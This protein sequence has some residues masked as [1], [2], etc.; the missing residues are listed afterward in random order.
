MSLRSAED[1]SPR[2]MTGGMAIARMLKAHGVGPVF[3]MGGFQLLPF[4]EGARQMGIDHYLIDDE[5]SGAFAADAF[6]RVS[7]RVGVVDATLGPGATNLVTGLAE[8]H[9]AGVPI[10]AIIGDAHRL[11]AG[12]N[13][14][15]ETRQLDVLAPVCKAVL[16]IEDTARIPEL[17][18]RAFGL[19]TSG[20]PGPV[21]VSVPEDI[22]HANVTFAD[23]DFWSDPV[24]V[25]GTARRVRPDGIDVQRAAEV[26]GSAA[27]PLIL[28]GGGVHLSGGY[29]ELAAL[30]AAQSIPVAHTLS[31][32]GAI[33]CTHPLSVG[34]FGR[35][36]RIANDLINESD[37]LLVVG[38][39][40][41]EIAT[42]RYVLPPDGVPLIQLDIDPGEI[43]R[44]ARTTVGLW[45]DAGLGMHDLH[46]AVGSATVDRSAYVEDVAER[47]EQ[48]YASTAERYASDERPIS[49]GRVMGEFNDLLSEDAI[50][51]ADGGFASHWAG[52]LYDTKRAGR[53]FV[54]DRGFA[55][56]GYGLP[57]SLGA[58]LAAGNAPVVGV[59]GDGGFNMSAGGLE[60]AQRIGAPFTLVVVNNA[61]SGYVKALQHAVYGPESYSASDLSELNFARIA[62][63][64]GCR[65]IRVEDPNDLGPALTEAIGCT[66]AP[67]VLDVVV[68]RDAG[69]MLPSADSRTL[70]VAPGDRPA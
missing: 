8:S 31:G 49:M 24:A 58:K 57:G 64:Y 65:G 70:T 28:A 50:V 35:Y 7:G 38:C 1:R 6:A 13:M 21:V 53:G 9:N 60:V 61:A 4:Y 33:A 66:D 42:K 18:R 5:R 46:E 11:H 2:S 51:V 37:C 30:A 12:K 10:V 26:L 68:T 55:S 52:L 36:D 25:G 23:D 45:G 40:L 32:K 29:R 59:T 20:R 47:R 3:G 43:G 17:I 15:Q 39:K 19:A 44:W 69:K 67:T 56:I 54:S 14:T 62:E 48:W 22:S 16:R 63:S 41:G 34:L 27:R